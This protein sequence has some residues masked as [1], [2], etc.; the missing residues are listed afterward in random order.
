MI[1]K[2]TDSLGHRSILIRTAFAMP[3]RQNAQKNLRGYQSQFVT[4]DLVT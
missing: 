2:C 3:Y 1:A 4:G